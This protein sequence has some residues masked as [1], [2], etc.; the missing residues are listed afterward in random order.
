AQ[1]VV[2]VVNTV[3]EGVNGVLS[4][5]PSVC[6]GSPD[7]LRACR[8]ALDPSFDAG[9]PD[10]GTIDAG[11]GDAGVDAGNP[12][13]AGDVADAG[14]SPPNPRGGC[15]CNGAPGILALLALLPWRARRE[16]NRP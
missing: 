5:K 1:L 16:R 10:A 9:V 12:A 8:I 14:M 4:R 11:A 15:G 6:I 3:R 7:E 13:D 2:A